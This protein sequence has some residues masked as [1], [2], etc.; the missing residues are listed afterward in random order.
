MMRYNP[1]PSLLP[2]ILSL[3]LLS[4]T[5]VAHGHH[6]RHPFW[7]TPAIA[8]YGA[9]H[10]WPHEVDRPL[11]SGV[12][13]AVFYIPNWPGSKKGIDPELARVALMVNVFRAEHVPLK[14]LHFVVVF[15]GA[16][17]PAALRSAP[18]EQHFHTV[19]ANLTLLRRLEHAG[20]RFRLCGVALA[21]WGFKPSD[22]VPGVK[23]VPTGPSTLILYGDRGYPLIFF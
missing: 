10:L 4:G 18:Y 20:V 21:G 15:D 5:A 17:V 7:T 6:A 13:R 11:P 8:G 16:A 9:I 19:N 3:L 2:V 22:L 23:V 12:Y 14:Q 1:K